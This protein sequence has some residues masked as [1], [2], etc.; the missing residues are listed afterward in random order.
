MRRLELVLFLLL[1]FVLP[2]FGQQGVA[3]LV[4]TDATDPAPLH[5]TKELP[6]YFPQGIITTT[7]PILQRQEY[8]RF[9][10]ATNS[11]FQGSKDTFQE[12][13]P[14]SDSVTLQTD[15]VST[16]SV[17][18]N[19]ANLK[20]VFDH[21]VELPNGG[22]RVTDLCHQYIITAHQLVVAA[23]D[24]QHVVREAAQD[25]YDYYS[26]TY[27]LALDARAKKLGIPV[28]ELEAQL[29]ES[30]PDRK[31]VT[32]REFNSLP[33]PSKVSDFVPRELHLGYNIPLG[34][35]LGVTWL[36]SGVIYYNPDARLVDFLTGKPKV[37]AHE[38]VHGNINIQKF[39][40]SEAFD[41]EN[42]ASIP[43][44]LWAENQLDLPSHGYFADLREIDE[45]YFSF[46]F[47]QMKKDTF[48]FDFAGNLVIDE[49]AYRYYY[50]QLDTIKKENLDFFQNVTIPEYY[51]DPLWWGAVNN[52]RGDKNSV[53]RMTMALHYNPTILG[54]AKPTLDWL[55]SNRETITSTA[56]DAFRRGASPSSGA[57]NVSRVPASL[58]ELYSKMFT[59]TERASIQAYYTKHPD[60]LQALL[61][62]KPQDA[63]QVLQGFKNSAGKVTV[64]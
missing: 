34:G 38:M 3:I 42:L 36:N 44:G 33:K 4:P 45:I 27:Q 23:N 18:E 2:V 64:Q 6:Y 29:D 41:V 8:M 12:T 59:S 30:M 20:I 11:C 26:K 63:L 53:F 62:M 52:I 10:T 46:D 1:A 50:A 9:L 15:I 17:T 56:E 37:M 39:P 55:E 28:K 57:M 13:I 21:V 25:D 54:G 24:L 14:G 5:L 60:Q 58:L 48:K 43:E 31:D 49:K 61:K 7:D 47:D 19:P 32:Y 35:I 16:D 51:S 40:M 22:Y